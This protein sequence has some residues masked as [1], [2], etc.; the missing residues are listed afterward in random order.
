MERA[1]IIRI[2]AMGILSKI[3]REKDSLMTDGDV[4][5]FVVESF[6]TCVTVSKGELTQ[7]W[8]YV[9][10]KLSREGAADILIMGIRA[11]IG[12][13]ITEE[14]SIVV[15]KTFQEILPRN[16]IW[17]TCDDPEI[18]LW[19]HRILSDIAYYPYIVK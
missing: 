16:D 8:F 2:K 17:S 19:R 11:G 6:E 7:A 4:C 5:K 13:V 10:H 18:S 12:A 14:I 15:E 9:L 1:G 3:S